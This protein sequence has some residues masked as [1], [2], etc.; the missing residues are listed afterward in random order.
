MPRC[1]ATRPTSSRRWPSS[2]AR[3]TVWEPGLAHGSHAGRSRNG[4]GRHIG[5]QHCQQGRRARTVSANHT[6]IVGKFAPQMAVVMSVPPQRLV[7]NGVA[8]ENI[9][10]SGAPGAPLHLVGE[11]TIPGFPAG[12]VGANGLFTDRTLPAGT[13]LF[14]LQQPYGDRRQ[15]HAHVRRPRVPVAAGRLGPRRLRHGCPQG[16]RSPDIPPWPGRQSALV[17]KGLDDGYCQTRPSEGC[18]ATV[19][20]E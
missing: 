9:S 6:T 15:R 14:E 3:L 8:S 16:C 18:L 17:G 19:T 12:T 7:S 11:S 5:D 1:A 4:H 20:A 2:P 13:Y 10:T